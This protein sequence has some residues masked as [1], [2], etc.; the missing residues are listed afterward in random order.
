MAGGAGGAGWSGILLARGVE[1]LDTAELGRQLPDFAPGLAWGSIGA[2]QGSPNHEAEAWSVEAV[3]AVLSKDSAQAQRALNVLR[4]TY[5]PRELSI[6]AQT[7]KHGHGLW[8][9]EQMA[10]SAHTHQ[11]LTGAVFARI[12]AVIAK[13]D[14]L[15]RLTSRLLQV[16]VGALKC[17]S[18]PDLQ[19]WSAGCRSE[20]KPIATEGSAWLRYVVTGNPGDKQYKRKGEAAWRDQMNLPLRGIRCLRETLHDDLGGAAEAPIST[21]R[22]KYTMTVY[23]GHAA[24]LVVMP[25]HPSMKPGNLCDWV[26]VPYVSSDIGK[27]AAQVTWSSDFQKPVPEPPRGAYALRFPG[28]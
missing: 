3:R 28:M 5:L 18:T 21:C 2:P 19:M 20:G 7:G 27:T 17:V 26:Y 12:A 15:L 16:T 10:P 13:D 9:N 23:R 4:Y 22:L 8:S 14:E 24:H 11:H 1:V 6:G 25:R